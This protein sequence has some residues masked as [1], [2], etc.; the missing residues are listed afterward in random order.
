[1]FDA[2]SRYYA[3]ETASYTLANGQVVTYKR[4]RFLPRAESLPLLVEVTVQQGQRLDQITAEQLG[5]PTQF[6]RI[7]DANNAMNPVLL[8]DEPGRVLRVPVPQPG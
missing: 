5:D 7:A 4:R 1:M 6:W 2:A 3:L 8:T